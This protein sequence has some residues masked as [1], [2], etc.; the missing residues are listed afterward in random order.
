MYKTTT[1]NLSII[2]VFFIASSKNNYSSFLFRESCKK[3]AVGKY[4]TPMMGQCCREGVIPFVPENLELI[5]PPNRIWLFPY[6][7]IIK[8][9]KFAFLHIYPQ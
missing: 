2:F 3:C 7:Y 5:S 4:R 8:D 9:T 1:Y 6:R